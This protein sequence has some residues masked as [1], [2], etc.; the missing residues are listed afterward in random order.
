MSKAVYL[1]LFLVPL[2]ALS[3]PPPHVVGPAP[4][5]PPAAN[6]FG[7]VE[8]RF[9]GDGL[10]SIKYKSV[11]FLADSDFQ[12]YW[13]ALTDSGGKTVGGDTSHTTSV[14]AVARSVTK[15]FAWGKVRAVYSADA[16]RLNIAVTISNETTST[17]DGFILALGAL[18]FPATPKE[19]DGSLIIGH[20]VG[21]PTA[22]MV[23][24]GSGAMVLA[25]EDVTTPLMT[26]LVWPNNKPTNTIFPLWVNTGSVGMYPSNLPCIDTPIAPGKSL[27]FTLSLRFGPAGATITDLA[28]DIFD[29]FRTAFPGQLRWDDRRPIA[30]LHLESSGQH[31]ATNPRGWFNDSQLD[32]TTPA[33]VDGFHTRVLKYADDSIAIMKSMNAQGMITWDIEGGEFEQGTTYIGDPRLIP[34]LAPEMAGVADTYF[35]R[36]RDA[37]LA[38]GVTL[39][40]THLVIPGN[41]Q[42][43]YQTEAAN[44]AKD[45]IDKIAY[46]KNRWGA[47]LFYVD[48]NGDINLPIDARIFRKV[49]DAHPDVLLIPECSNMLYYSFSAPYCQMRP[50]RFATS[51]AM[52]LGYPQAFSV[53][54][55]DWEI[56]DANHDAILAGV[57][58]GDILMFLGWWNEPGNARVKQIYDEAAK[59]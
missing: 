14:D 45:L 9:D 6:S 3:A 42:P 17:L 25:N 20:N 51:P 4:S 47:T 30:A 24:Y 8:M 23:S 34:T 10:A 2:L 11:E 58:H 50:G 57:K 7:K 16:N 53:I 36:F 15:K 29:K 44:P 12:I 27:S 18:N 55:V 33:G 35:K 1:L 21:S 43:A 54:R 22:S 5:I 32:I 52:M 49:A 59:Q 26:A 40:P 31:Y 38:V 13:A 41:G 46:A 39:R 37:G 48:S 19:Y 56:M 28:G